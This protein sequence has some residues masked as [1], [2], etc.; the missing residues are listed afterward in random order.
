MIPARFPAARLRRNRHDGFTRRLVAENSLSVADLIWPVFVIAGEN[1]ETAVA[2]MPGV[3]RVSIDRLA[4]HVEPA[5]RLGI[6]AVALFPVIPLEHRDQEGAESANP[7]NLMC[8]SARS[9]PDR[10]RGT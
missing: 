1:T 3:R 8:R 7:D 9:R 5:V 4:A 10:R 6:P 2:S